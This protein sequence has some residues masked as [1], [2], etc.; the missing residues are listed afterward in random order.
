MLD[1]IHCKKKNMAAHFCWDS[2][3]TF[4]QL[5]IL[6]ILCSTS[7]QALHTSAFV[8]RTSP[9]RAPSSVAKLQAVPR[10]FDSYTTTT[11]T[12]TT[13]DSLS[14]VRELALY[15]SRGAHEPGYSL[16]G[17][18]HMLMLSRWVASQKTQ[19][20]SMCSISGSQM[21]SERSVMCRNWNSFHRDLH[22]YTWHSD[23]TVTCFHFW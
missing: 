18:L 12:Y 14:S 15:Y 20:F 17:Y 13:R 23:K 8:A 1:L 9:L 16:Y 7:L 6:G 4:S 2:L 19:S 22:F 21:H 5:P 10:K 3:M 11:N